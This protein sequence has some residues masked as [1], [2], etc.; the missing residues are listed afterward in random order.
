MFY[1]PGANHAPH[2]V[3][4]EWAD[5]YKGAFDDGYEAR[6]VGWSTTWSSRASSTTR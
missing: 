6:S 2:H 5:K 4:A 3:A 1:C